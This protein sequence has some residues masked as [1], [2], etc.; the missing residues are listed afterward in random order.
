MLVSAGANNVLVSAGGS[1]FVLRS[2]EGKWPLLAPVL[3]EGSSINAASLEHA[4]RW[5]IIS[6]LGSPGTLQIAVSTL[7]VHG[8]FALPSIQDQPQ[9]P[10]GSIQAKSSDP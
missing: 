9:F 10:L 6:P 4:P 5:V 8:L 3:L 7:Y 2:M 1:V